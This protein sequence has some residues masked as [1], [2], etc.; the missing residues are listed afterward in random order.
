MTPSTAVLADLIER[1]RRREA[2]RSRLARIVA[3]AAACC[4]ASGGLIARLGRMM[5][6]ASAA[7]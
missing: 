4:R 1:D 5:R 3:Q 7:C 2:G 6:P